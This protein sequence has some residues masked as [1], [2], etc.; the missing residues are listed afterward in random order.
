M[1]NI[2]MYIYI[3]HIFLIPELYSAR[4]WEW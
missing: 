2:Y 4:F 1:S 3:K